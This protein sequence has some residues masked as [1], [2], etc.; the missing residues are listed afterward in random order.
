MV[1]AHR[2]RRPAFAEKSSARRRIARQLRCQDLDLSDDKKKKLAEKYGAE[3]RKVM[4]RMMTAM[5]SRMGEE[6]P[7]MEGVLKGM[8]ESMRD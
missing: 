6:L 2:G 8:Q 3:L 4:G 1:V 7:A 5:M